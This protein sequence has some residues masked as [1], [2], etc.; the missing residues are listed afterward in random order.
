M[1]LWTETSSLPVALVETDRSLDL[2][3]LSAQTVDMLGS[4]VASVNR[5]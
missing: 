3:H 5:E 4:T 2:L 1:A